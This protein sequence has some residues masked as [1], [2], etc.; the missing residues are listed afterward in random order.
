[1]KGCGTVEDSSSDVSSVT[2][3]VFDSLRRGDT[4]ESALRKSLLKLSNIVSQD[5]TLRAA[6]QDER[7]LRL[8]EVHE[9]L[10]NGWTKA[11][12][13]LNKGREFKSHEHLVRFVRLQVAQ[14]S[15]I[16]AYREVTNERQ[17][18]DLTYFSKVL[19]EEL[20]K[21]TIQP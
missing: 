13:G 3:I 7:G 6:D 17:E 15:A 11:I 12:E 2:L 18:L 8:L 9:Q 1:M 10:V 19:T 14:A 21:A 16:G 20:M 5:R 4:V